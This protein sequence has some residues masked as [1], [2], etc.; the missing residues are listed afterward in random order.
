MS[1]KIIRLHGGGAIGFRRLR[2]DLTPQPPLNAPQVYAIDNPRDPSGFL[3]SHSLEASSLTT[4]LISPAEVAALLGVSVRS[5]ERWRCQ[6][7]GPHFVRLSAKGRVR[8]RPDHVAAWIEQ[9]AR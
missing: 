6:G 3:N 5:L 2:A 7:R 1:L 8:Y 9:A 4:T